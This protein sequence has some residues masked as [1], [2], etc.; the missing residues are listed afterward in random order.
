MAR[1]RYRRFALTLVE[2]LI[3]IA[4]LGTLIALLLP[5]V[6]HA[7]R[8]KPNDRIDSNVL[9]SNDLGHGTIVWTAALPDSR[10]VVFGIRS[11][12]GEEFAVLSR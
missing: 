6:L 5:A 4:I 3:I 12:S 10:G 1:T 9:I 8:S 11:P 7:Y 2:L